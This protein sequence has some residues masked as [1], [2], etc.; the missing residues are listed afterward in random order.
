MD[1]HSDNPSEEDLFMLP[2][3][4]M[5]MSSI[6]PADGSHKDG[7]KE[8]IEIFVSQDV[9]RLMLIELT[10]SCARQ[11]RGPWSISSAQHNTI[12]GGVDIQEWRYSDTPYQ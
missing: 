7:I 6:V 12:S 1:A 5:D 11:M 2:P 8:S 4:V 9:Y 10:K 3:P